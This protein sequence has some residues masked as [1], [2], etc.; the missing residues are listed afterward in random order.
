MRK[1][2]IVVSAI[3][4]CVILAFW[5]IRL[6]IRKTIDT[7]KHSGNIYSSI[8]QDPK[9]PYVGIWKTDST[10]NFG[11]IIDEAST[12]QYSVSFFGPGG[13]FKPGTWMP[14]TTVIND[15]SYRIIDK[16][17]IEINKGFGFTRYYRM[18]NVEQREKE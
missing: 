4:L 15:S 10:V 2:F 1:K 11:I 6:S 14:N 3:L 12:D 18:S 17:I 5:A 16:D 8:K 7:A 13:R 9:Y